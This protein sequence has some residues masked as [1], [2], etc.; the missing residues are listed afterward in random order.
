[1]SIQ[2]RQKILSDGRKSLYLDIYHNGK[3]NYE[4]LKI[5]LTKDKIQNKE[6]LKLAE[7]IKAKRILDIKNSEHGFQPQFKNKANFIE[8]FSSLA[9][10]KEPGPKYIWGT[11]NKTL[12][13]YAGSKLRFSDVTEEWLE[14]FKGFLLS[15]VSKNTARTYFSKVRVC[16]RQ[17][18]KDGIIVKN[19][20]IKVAPVPK[21][22][23]ERVYLT[24]EELE[25][26]INT[27][28][29]YPEVKRAFLF[30]C[31]TGLRLSDIEK[32]TWGEIKGDKLQFKQKK[33]GGFEYV[34]LNT[35]AMKIVRKNLDKNVFPTP[36]KKVFDLPSR[37][38]ITYKVPM[39]RMKA[40]IEKKVTFHSARHTFATLLITADT[41]LYTVS[42][43]L[44][45]KDF[46]TTQIYAQIVDKKKEEAVARL[47]EIKMNI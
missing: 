4:F 18:L 7:S 16:I 5:Y 29:Q 40:G 35:S 14:E 31:F 1:M 19:P 44:G 32:L 22:E 43:L 12:K 45:H 33:T 13:K 24:Q 6:L 30:S 9:D 17:A 38:T 27:P 25:K 28:C 47:P 11:V 21:D 46:R 20:L 39:W 37:S 23:T 34:P 10:K 42:K 3:R 8:F 26:M 41:D 36:N 15:N 2:I